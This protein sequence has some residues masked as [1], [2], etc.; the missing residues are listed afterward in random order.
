MDKTQDQLK[1]PPLKNHQLRNYPFHLLLWSICIGGGM[2]I[3][4]KEGSAKVPALSKQSIY[5]GMVDQIDPPW[6][7]I[8]SEAGP[9]FYLSTPL[10]YSSLKE[11]EWVIYITA[12]QSVHTR[13]YPLNTEGITQFKQRISQ[14]T[15]E[16]LNQL[17]QQGAGSSFSLF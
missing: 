10:S 11:G 2:G 14:A 9:T 3:H 12:N 8:V 1:M 4:I 16:K 15:Q 6:I 13:I 7:V 17:K 5:L